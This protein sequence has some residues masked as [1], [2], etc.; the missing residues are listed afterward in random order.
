MSQLD[1]TSNPKSRGSIPSAEL[2]RRTRALLARIPDPR[3]AATVCG[4][5]EAPFLR[6]ILG[7]P[8][9]SDT[10]AKIEAGLS[11]AEAE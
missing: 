9:Y 11:R 7:L 3:R 10:L 8:V 1:L 5:A 6:V 4:V 2:T